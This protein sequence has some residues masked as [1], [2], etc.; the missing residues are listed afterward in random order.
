M[1]SD[2][3]SSSHGELFGCCFGG[4]F[5]KKIHFSSQELVYPG[6]KQQLNEIQEP[7][8]APPID[9]PP[10]SLHDN[11]AKSHTNSHD[12][13]LLSSPE[14][15]SVL[16]QLEIRAGG[17]SNEQYIY[18]HDKDTTYLLGKLL[19]KVLAERFDQINFV[20]NSFSLGWFCKV[21]RI[22]G[23]KEPTDLCWK[24]YF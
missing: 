8:D 4:L 22:E 5:L 19:G 1:K 17:T 10:Y 6:E 21:F 23:H 12:F 16:N 9:P 20:N 13:G 14:N 7:T 3:K 11:N 2:K 24:D 15:R 18:D